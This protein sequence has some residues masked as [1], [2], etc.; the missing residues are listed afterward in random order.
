ME[1][2]SVGVEGAYRLYSTCKDEMRTW[3]LDVRPLKE[4][5]KG[6]LAQAYCIRLTSDQK[7]LLD[8]SKNSYS[9]KWS[10]ECWCGKPVFV[11]G[12]P[13]LKKDHPVIEY[14]RKD[15]QAH[16]I[17]VFRGG[18]EAIG[19]HY[20]F[21]VTTS[22]KAN[23]HKRP[24]PGELIHGVL[25]L[26]DWDH[27]NDSCQLEDLRIGSILTIHNH[28]ENLRPP[29]GVRHLKIE[30]PDVE[31]F[32]ISK[33]FS[34]S[35]DF[36]EEAR[37][38]GHAALV[39][40]GAGASRSAV[41]CIAYLMRKNLWPMQTA[42]Q[43]AVEQRSIVQPNPGF[44]RCLT[45]LEAALGLSKGNASLRREFGA[46]IAG[47]KVEVKEKQP[48]EPRRHSDGGGEGRNEEG[49]GACSDRG[50]AG[51]HRRKRDRESE[52]DS[53]CSGEG[54]VLEVLKD[55]Q[56]ISTIEVPA[57]RRNQRCMFGRAPTCDIKLEHLSVSRQHAQLTRDDAG[58]LF[59]TDLSTSH[60]TNVDD[61][62][63]RANA[64]KQLHPGSLI[65]F[66]ASTRVYRVAVS[67]TEAKHSRH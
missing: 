66:G 57:L 26:G 40:C 60:G 37:R 2:R 1:V 38:R 27:A 14:L 31:S 15:G 62:W 11:Y 3:I 22:I 58:M 23:M 32:D 59:I 61:K 44:L 10:N 53:V 65:R 45:A 4:F 30:A 34:E 39:H 48:G 52:D 20:P 67:G 29:H 19:E 43:H 35:Y 56:C 49:S 21:L 6:H 63:L 36:I 46:K 12:D 8:Y 5:K 33:H 18:L 42:L 47:D 50:L 54:V 41:L 25:Y 9:I 55:G 7:A 51:E 64:P 17:S 13:D 28:P 16:S 24:Y